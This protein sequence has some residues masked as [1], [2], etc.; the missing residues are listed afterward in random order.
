[1]GMAPA[2]TIKLVP[3]PSNASS[4]DWYDRFFWSKRQGGLVVAQKQGVRLACGKSQPDPLPAE[5]RSVPVCRELVAPSRRRVTLDPRSQN[6]LAGPS[7]VM[8]RREPTVHVECTPCANT[9]ALAF[10]RIDHEPYF[11]MQQDVRT[12]SAPSLLIRR[13]R[14]RL[15]KVQSTGNCQRGTRLA[16]HST[17]GS[18]GYRAPATG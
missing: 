17:E 18:P 3:L 14:G 4:L 12:F 5:S 7:Q 11:L 10:A 1:M 2:P 8:S 13:R 9:G 16:H 15:K 6:G